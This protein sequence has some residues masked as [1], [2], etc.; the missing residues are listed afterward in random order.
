MGGDAYSRTA[1]NRASNASAAKERRRNARH[2]KAITS[3]CRVYVG[4]KNVQTG[5]SVRKRDVSQRTV[6]HV[7]E[8]ESAIPRRAC[9]GS[10]RIVEQKRRRS[11]SRL[12]NEIKMEN[13]T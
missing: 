7:A 13:E 5:R 9:V 4:G 12:G 8:A 6:R 3:A 1:A 10:V 2:A 11:V